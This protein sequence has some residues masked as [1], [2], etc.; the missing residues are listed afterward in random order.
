MLEWSLR[1]GLF[2]LIL[3]AQAARAEVVPDPALRAALMDA[4]KAADS[5][6]DRFNAEVWLADM[7]DRLSR[8]RPNAFPDLPERLAFLRLLHSEA[9]RAHLTPEVVMAV[10]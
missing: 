9:T 3:S 7:S 6:E 1:V 5:F 4:V 2:A 8:F 10:I